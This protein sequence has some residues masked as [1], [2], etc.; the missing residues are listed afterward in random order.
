MK[1]LLSSGKKNSQA[2]HE[3]NLIYGKAVY[4]TSQPE[5]WLLIKER[6]SLP[7]KEIRLVSNECNK[8]MKEAITC[9]GSA[10]DERQ[11]DSEGS[12]LL[13]FALNASALDLGYLGTRCLLCRRGGQK[14]KN[15]HLWPNSI[16]ERIYKAEYRGTTKPFLFG[17]NINQPKFGRQCTFYMFCYRC[18]E[19]LSQ[20]GEDQFAKLL[21]HLQRAP[22]DTHT[23]DS[24]LYSF[25]IG[26]V[27]RE[28]A[29][30]A[31]S[32]VVNEQELY[33]AFLL[34]RKHLFTL[35]A[36]IDKK[37]LPTYAE[38]EGYQFQSICA[39]TTG[40]SDLSVYI[41]NC[42]AKQASSKDKMIHYYSEYCHCS[43]SV[44][45]CRLSD[46]K[47]DLSGRVH[48]LQVYLNGIHFLVKFKASE[49]CPIDERFLILPQPTSTQISVI[50][51]EDVNSIPEGVWSVLRHT[52]SIS[53]D[54]RMRCYQAISDLTLCNLTESDSQL[55]NS[56]SA[57][58]TNSTLL[59]SQ[60]IDPT[61]EV[62]IL[63]DSIRNSGAS[64]LSLPSLCMFNLLP[65]SFSINVNKPGELP[66]CLPDEHKVILH[67]SGQLGEL[68]ASYFLCMD[69]SV[70]SQNFYVIFVYSDDAN[71]DLQIA[72]G[73][74]ITAE[75][76]PV[77]SS[78]LLNDRP[79]MESLPHPFSIPVMQEM[80]D[81][82]LPS[83]LYSKG[84]KSMKH[85]MHL[86]DCRR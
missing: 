31:M 51:V 13:D 64:M 58:M 65:K 23:Y 36:K 75:D 44:A 10:L 27:F 29:T 30:E 86:L 3:I 72:D 60:P 84:I 47:L 42:M 26:I 22:G 80:I 67:L 61:S 16:L 38:E 17:K 9:L 63:T 76:E 41:M 56:T 28:L 8:K 55:H 50:P 66:L 74:N 46:A 83:L 49:N 4:Y 2:A 43:G 15:S 24:W 21:D 5:L 59:P 70:D 54:L 35:S 37:Y 71:S 53:F 33:N 48:F 81:Q 19:L 62:D 1:K 69:S 34:C 25:A 52:G 20:N 82:Q 73:V 78:F 68:L 32:Y 79:R 45:T 57:V 12:K 39:Y 77:V 11:I 40:C 6:D 7:E 18:E 85:L 14:L